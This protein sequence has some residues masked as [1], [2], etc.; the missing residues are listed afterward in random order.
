[1]VVAQTFQAQIEQSGRE[2][3]GFLVLLGG[4]QILDFPYQRIVM[5]RLI[6][7]FS[8]GLEENFLPFLHF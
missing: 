2:C 5:V 8:K 6:T 7:Q 3:D 4:Y 1:L